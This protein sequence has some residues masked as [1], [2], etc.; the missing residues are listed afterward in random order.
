MFPKKDD[1][2]HIEFDAKHPF[3]WRGS[4]LPKTDADIWLAAAFADF[5]KVIALENAIAFQDDETETKTTRTADAA[6]DDDDE[7]DDAKTHPSKKKPSHDDDLREGRDLVDL[8]LFQHESNWLT[9]VRRVGR[10][11][12]L[13]ETKS[14]FA[15]SD[16][17]RIASGK[18][19][20]LLS[21]LRKQMGA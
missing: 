12:P 16:W 10:D 13:T 9:A 3:A 20:M 15:Q 18:G 7:S 4:L 2:L 19:V 17:Y 6:D 21:A 1:P 14:D 8:A 5:E 11:I